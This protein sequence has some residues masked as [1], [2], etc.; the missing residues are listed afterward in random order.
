MGTQKEIAETSRK[1]KAE[2]VLAVKGNQ[3]TLYEEPKL[4]FLD[5]EV[6][7]GKN[8]KGLLQERGKGGPWT[9]RE[10]EILSDRRDRLV[11]GEEGMEKDQKYWNQKRRFRIKRGA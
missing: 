1:K 5:P 3:E 11:A 8:A 7:E 10:A 9:D 2:Y 4:Y 6:Q